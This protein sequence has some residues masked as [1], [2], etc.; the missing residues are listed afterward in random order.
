M[1]LY[2]LN[3]DKKYLLACSFGPD[4]MALFHLLVLDGFNFDCAIVNYHLREE[5]NSEVEELIKYAKK[6]SIHVNVLDVKEKILKNIESKCREI[7]YQYFS[8]LVKE[9]GYEAVLVA[10]NQDDLIETYLLQKERQNCPIYY[11]ISELTVIKGVRIHRPLLDFS[12]AQLLDICD[13]NNVPYSIDKTNFD[14]S[15]KRNRIRHQYVANLSKENR[16]EIIN[17]IA[18][19]NKELSLLISK[20]K[21]ANL[22]SIKY[23][24]SL[25]ENSRQ[26]ALN[27][28]AGQLSDYCFLSKQNV[29]QVI[30]V[31][32]SNKPNGQFKIKEGLFVIKEYD[33]FDLSD[34]K[35]DQVQYSFLVNSPSKLETE[36]FYL[37]FSEDASN[38]NVHSFDYP[39][40]VRN[41]KSSDEYVI[42]GYKVSVRR[43]F[44]DWKIP[45][46]KRLIWPVILNKDGK[47]IYIPRYQKDFIPDSNCNFYVK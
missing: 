1:T 46:R 22:K 19:K 29:G 23:I 6:F 16:A 21:K 34:S 45:Y 37:D 8:D 17:E 31:L 9:N 32:S 33:F 47:C 27:I 15:I 2:N 12:K 24:L 40:T 18:Y 14:L 36:F 26:Y 11:G 4:S 28:L 25:D 5:S 43:L 30:K 20:L 41:A 42:N 39:L 13:K 44:I 7:R 10:H 3:A 38:R 35:L